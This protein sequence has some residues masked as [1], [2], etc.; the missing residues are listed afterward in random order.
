VHRL[1][2]ELAAT[3]ELDRD[4]RASLAALVEDIER[5]LEDDPAH[6]VSIKERLETAALR[7]EAE[8]PSLA[9]ILGEVTDT[10]AKLGI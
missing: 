6:A 5:V 1:L 3:K 9:R 10:L 2:A 7:F 8:H 4:T